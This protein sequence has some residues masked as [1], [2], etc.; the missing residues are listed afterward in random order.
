ME[1][2]DELTIDELNLV[3]GGTGAPNAGALN[4]GVPE[5][6]DA[7]AR[8]AGGGQGSGIMYLV[9]NFKLVAV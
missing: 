4:A 2:R 7:S 8:K 5:A 9:F 1:K 3:S 6:A